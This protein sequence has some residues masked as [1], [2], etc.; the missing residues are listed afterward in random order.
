MNSC[1]V[2]NP[3]LRYKP[4]S[5]EEY[6]YPLLSTEFTKRE[7]DCLEKKEFPCNF[8]EPNDIMNAYKQ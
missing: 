1:A 7:N 5:I 2:F 8:P 6:Y 4:Y 3:D